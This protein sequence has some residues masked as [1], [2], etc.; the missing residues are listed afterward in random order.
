M[1]EWKSHEF[2]GKS[3][4]NT[5]GFAKQILEDRASALF[6]KWIYF[7]SIGNSSILKRESTPKFWETLSG[8]KIS[9]M[10]LPV[11]GSCKLT[12]LGL[13]QEKPE[14]TLE[15]RWSAARGK[16]LL[17]EHRRNRIRIQLLKPRQS[18]LG[19]GET[20]CSN[21]GA[22]FPELDA[23]ECS[24]CKASIPNLVSDWLIDANES[25]F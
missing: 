18:D 24:Y 1:V 23:M 19:F 3:D 10:F 7:E 16:D 25:T 21:C 22:P 14:A 8:K 4:I 9:P 12:Q 13:T 6:W 11:I 5:Q 20:S 2:E 17:P 15:F